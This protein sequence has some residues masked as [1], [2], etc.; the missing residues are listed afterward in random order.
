[1]KPLPSVGLPT[2]M[3]PRKSEA[4]WRDK[5]IQDLPRAKVSGLTHKDVHEARQIRDT[6]AADPGVVRRTLDEKIASGE[7]RYIRP[8]FLQYPV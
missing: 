5:V 8:V 1:M 7:E 4:R 2:N 3:T 6:E